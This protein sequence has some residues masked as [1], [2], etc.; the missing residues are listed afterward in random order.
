MTT[1]DVSNDT[2]ALIRI[3]YM[4]YYQNYKYKYCFYLLVSWYIGES[5]KIVAH[6]TQTGK[7]LC[8]W[9]YYKVFSMAEKD[10]IKLIQ[11]LHRSNRHVLPTKDWSKLY[12]TKTKMLYHSQLKGKSYTPNKDSKIEIF[13]HV[14]AANCQMKNI[15]LWFRFR[16]KIS[17]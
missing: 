14:L 3:C 7:N 8:E 1:N 17:K 9:R 11:V 10:N 2:T 6:A 5:E 12:Y 15:Y 13:M 16:R 4:L